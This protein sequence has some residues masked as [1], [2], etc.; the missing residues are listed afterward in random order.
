[1]IRA[2]IAQPKLLL[3]DEPSAALDSQSAQSIARLLADF[4]AAGGG[5]IVATHDEPFQRQLRGLCA[6][7]PA[8]I[9]LGS[10]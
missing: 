9:N 6:T 7:A 3:A 4:C 10:A 5:L 1:V 8:E 2:L